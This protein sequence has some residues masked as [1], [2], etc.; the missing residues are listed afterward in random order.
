MV[1]LLIA[2]QDRFRAEAQEVLRA[3]LGTAA[4]VTVDDTGARHQARNGFCTHIGND[5]FAWF[6]TTGSKRFYAGGRRTAG[7]GSGLCVA[8][9][10]SVN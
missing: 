6:G 8:S 4:W 1:R 5:R 9:G 10:V 3:G 7:H 2:D